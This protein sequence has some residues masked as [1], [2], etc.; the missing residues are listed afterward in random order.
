MFKT[1]IP[2]ATVRAVAGAF[3][4]NVS[5]YRIS[6]LTKEEKNTLFKDRGFKVLGV[7]K[8]YGNELHIFLGD[9][10]G[11]KIKT[12]LHEIGHAIFD[13]RLSER[14]RNYITALY[15]MDTVRPMVYDVNLSSVDEY[16]ADFCSLYFLDEIV[17]DYMFHIRR[18]LCSALDINHAIGNHKMTLLENKLKIMR[19]K[20]GRSKEMLNFI[21]FFGD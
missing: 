20:K 15:T 4:F 21:R 8:Y 14:S 16:W 11:E 18:V 5:F 12:E 10:K 2:S 7:I 1:Y 9:E 19:Y 13:Y 3:N 17:D 6:S